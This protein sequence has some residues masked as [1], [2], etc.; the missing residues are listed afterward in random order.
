MTE[1]E[2]DEARAV[3]FVRDAQD[4]ESGAWGRRGRREGDK[5]EADWRKHWTT[6]QVT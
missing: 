2:S 4:T 6:G 1:A 5:D 3:H